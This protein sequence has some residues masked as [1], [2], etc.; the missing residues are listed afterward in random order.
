[1]F[2]PFIEGKDG[3]VYVDT[4][5]LCTRQQYN[6][7]IAVILTTI[8]D[9]YPDWRFHQILTNIGLASTEDLW[10]E[11]SRKTLDILL[12]NEVVMRHFRKQEKKKA[13]VL[14]FNDFKAGKK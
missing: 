6:K 12:T 9:K 4:A 13:E 1:M 5:V 14:N 3:L 11:E 7:V 2:G 10:N 8:I